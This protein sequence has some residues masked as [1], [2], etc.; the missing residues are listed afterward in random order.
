MLTIHRGLSWKEPEAIRAVFETRFV[1][2]P[3]ATLSDPCW[4]WIGTVNTRGYGR[5]KVN[6]KHTA[7]HRISWRLYRSNPKGLFVCHHCDNPRCVNPSHLFLGTPKMN[8]ED[9]NNKGRRASFRG[10]K[11][12]RAKLTDGKILEI[13]RAW[14]ALSYGK[15]AA[16][17]SVDKALIARIIKRTSWKHVI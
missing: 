4:N 16:L 1:K 8:S 7:T 12:G 15:L 5:L 10:T 2:A 13:R 14:P 17:Y 3:H 9:C 6:G 11:N